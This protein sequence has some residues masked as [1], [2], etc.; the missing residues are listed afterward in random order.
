MRPLRLHPASNLCSSRGDLL[1][2]STPRATKGH[3]AP[4]RTCAYCCAYCCAYRCVRRPRASMVGKQGLP[5]M[6]AKSTTH[7]NN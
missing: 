5:C 6:R 7:G 4:T 1:H 3:V 2:S